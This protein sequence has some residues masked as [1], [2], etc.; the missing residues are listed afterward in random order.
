MIERN[1]LENQNTLSKELER[2]K[3]WRSNTEQ[4]KSKNNKQEDERRCMLT[5]MMMM[6]GLMVK[7]GESAR[8]RERE[9]RILAEQ[10][11]QQCMMAL[12]ERGGSR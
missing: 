1:T 3:L 2:S 8:E 12:C 5:M 6:K 11:R 7:G 9:D 4:S 10:A